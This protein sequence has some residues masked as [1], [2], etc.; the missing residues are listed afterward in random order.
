MARSLHAAL[1]PNGH[2]VHL[3][4]AGG[5]PACGSGVS[6]SYRVLARV[7]CRRCAA[8][9]PKLAALLREQP[10]VVGVDHSPL[11]AAV[12]RAL[13]NGDDRMPRQRAAFW[14]VLAP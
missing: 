13:E 10:L 14:P 12:R 6:A 4:T 8:K 2:L 9:H 11:Y 1:S 7:T 3:A 5:K